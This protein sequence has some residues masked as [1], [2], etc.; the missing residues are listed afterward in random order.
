M[1]LKIPGSLLRESSSLSTPTNSK[2]V[3]VMGDMADFFLLSE[4]E[5]RYEEP[6]FPLNPVSNRRRRVWIPYKRLNREMVEKLQA[7]EA[8]QSCIIKWKEKV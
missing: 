1:G 7:N 2:G 8:T 4:D 3:L 5:S 6:D